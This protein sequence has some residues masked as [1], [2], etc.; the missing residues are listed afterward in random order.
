MTL[1]KIHLSTALFL[2]VFL[3]AYSI[4]AV[5]F[6]HRKWVSHPSW[7]TGE[8]RKLPPGIT[9]ARVIAREWRG[10]L[11]SVENSPGYLK[12]RVTSSLGRSHEVTYSIATGDTEVKTTTISFLTTL[13]WIHISH[14]IWAYV[15]ILFALGLLTLGATGVYLWFR[16]RNERWIGGAVLLLGAGI[17]LALLI[18]MRLD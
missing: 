8:T 2:L 12:F 4:G 1:R 17:P 10:E 9:D 3:L 5:E 14:G 16:N 13:A 6:A 11:A 7:T 15:A 18:S